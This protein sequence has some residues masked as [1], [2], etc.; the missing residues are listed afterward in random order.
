MTASAG[1]FTDPFEDAES[2][3]SLLSGTESRPSGIVASVAWLLTRVLEPAGYAAGFLVA[4]GLWALLDRH[5]V[6]LAEVPTIALLVASAA[7]L[8]WAA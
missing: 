6:A 5:F 7:G 3:P 4:M 1:S 8:W 2:R